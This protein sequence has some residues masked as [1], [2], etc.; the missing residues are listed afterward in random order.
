MAHLDFSKNYIIEDDYV[1]LS[2][3]KIEHIE[4]L[5]D[6]SKEEN[7]WTYFLEKGSGQDDLTTYISSTINN[8]KHKKEYPFFI[9]M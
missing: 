7:L 8:R 5:L 2:P 1:K 3:L 9:L 4:S 6:I